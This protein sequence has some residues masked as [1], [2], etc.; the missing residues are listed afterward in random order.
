MDRG[1]RQE[2]A[3]AITVT[4][5]QTLLCYSERMAIRGV[6]E[7]ST[8][9]IRFGLLALGIDDW[10]LDR[11]ENLLVLALHHDACARIDV[12]PAD[13][14]REAGA[15]LG[16]N[17]RRGLEDYLEREPADRSIAVMGYEAIGEGESFTYRR[18]W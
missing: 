5:Q 4:Q 10:N 14:F 17:A 18:T 1:A 6:R 3:H 7:R 11:R 12:S 9:W 13:L 8:K 2:I 15:L 16:V